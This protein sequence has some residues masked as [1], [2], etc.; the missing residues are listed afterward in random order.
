MLDRDRT[1]QWFVHALEK[2]RREQNFAI[3]AFVIMPEHAHV[4]IFPRSKV[5]STSAIEKAIKQSCARR[6]LA[7]LR[8][9]HPAWLEKLRGALTEQGQ[10]YHFWQPG[11]GYD[12]NVVEDHTAWASIEYFHMNPVRRGLVDIPTDWVWSSARAYAGFEEV[13]MD[14]DLCPVVHH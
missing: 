10:R 4:L 3:W 13:V 7:W 6:A 11:G 8:K 1:R 5:Y 12:R 2:S 9:N 14:V